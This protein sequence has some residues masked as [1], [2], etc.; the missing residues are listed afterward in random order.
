MHILVTGATGFIGSHL[1]RAL[2]QAGHH[3]TALVRASSNRS[4][5]KDLPVRYAV[6][7]LLQPDSLLNAM[8]GI[9]VVYH[10]GGMVARWAEPQ[11]MIASHI[12]GTSHIVQAALSCGVRRFIHTSSVAALG[13]PPVR[14]KSQEEIPI[15]NETHQWNYKAEIWPYGYGKHMAEQEVLAAAEDG[16][17][18][19]ILNPSAVFG[20]GDVHRVDTG[21]VARLSRRGLPVTMPGGVNVVHIDDVIAGHVAALTEGQSGERYILGGHNISH[22]DMMTTIATL[23][24]TISPL[25]T[26]PLGLVRPVARLILWM[27]RSEAI[28][29]RAEMLHLAG[30]YFYYDISKAQNAFG[31]GHPRSFSSA[32][33]E[34][35]AWLPQAQSR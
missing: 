5:L 30:Y 31:L 3:V 10:C 34:L 13:I 7:D 25:I 17:E 15:L 12:Q 32:I 28:H 29:I 8:Q 26:I 19:V 23:A 33:K 1:C 21:I 18:A 22:K 16:L 20:A 2:T 14:P 9:E 24:G 6:G 35:L 27:R 4:V 11:A